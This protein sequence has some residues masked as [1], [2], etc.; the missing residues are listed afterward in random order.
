MS[1]RSMVRVSKPIQVIVDY[2]LDQKTIVEAGNYHLVSSEIFDI[3]QTLSLLMECDRTEIVDV[4]LVSM[5]QSTSTD[6]ILNRLDCEGFR[7]ATLPEL[8]ALGA[9]CPWLQ[10]GFRI[11]AL[12]TQCCGECGAME[13]PMLCEI[14]DWRHLCMVQAGPANGLWKASDR[15]LAVRKRRISTSLIP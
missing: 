3:V 12:G 4:F 7:P 9:T 14:N 10:L 6:K 13:V 15:F 5:G 1:E 8:L 11:I 2:R